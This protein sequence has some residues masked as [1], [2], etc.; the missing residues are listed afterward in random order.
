MAE[1]LPGVAVAVTVLAA[2]VIGRAVQDRRGAVTPE[3]LLRIRGLTVSYPTAGRDILTGVD[4]DAPAGATVAVLGPSGAGKSTLVVAIAGLLP[5]GARVSGEIWFDGV[6][7]HRLAEGAR[8]RLRD[9]TSRSSRRIRRSPSIRC[10]RSVS[11]SPRHCSSTAWPAVRRPRRR[12]SSCCDPPDSPI[13]RRW[14][15]ATRTTCPGMRQRALVACALAAEPDSSW[16]TSRP[17]PSTRCRRPECS[18]TW[19]T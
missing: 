6:A 7:L 4:L 19:P 2:T 1:H 5:P 10:F 15:S 12:P 11:R 18:T 3:P 8:R 17:A 9:G 16:P 13:P 14:P